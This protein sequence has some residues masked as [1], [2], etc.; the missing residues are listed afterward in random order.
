[1]NPETGA[2][3]RSRPVHDRPVKAAAKRAAD[4]ALSA[5]A[6]SSKGWYTTDEEE[7]KKRV[8]RGETEPMK[9]ENL[10]PGEALFGTFAVVS[11][12]SGVPYTVEIRSLGT[13]DNSCS[14]PDFQVNGLGTCKHIEAVLNRLRKRHPA[15]FRRG[16]AGGSSRV[17]I[18][19]NRRGRIE[20]A[21]SLPPR[22]MPAL[23]KFV[24]RFF[25]T[26]G[27]MRQRAEDAVP[28]I[29]RAIDELPDHLRPG[30]RLAREVTEWAAAKARAS[31]R[32]AARDAFLA[33]VKAGRR[34][35]HVLNHSL[36]PYQQEGMLHLAF[37][38]RVMLVD[39]MG[40]GKTVQAIAACALLRE[41]RGVERVLVVTP[42]SLKTEWE[43]QIKKFTGL[44]YRII[45]GLKHGRTPAYREP[46]F[47][48]LVNYEQ[49]LRDVAEINSLLSPDIVI[50]DEAQRIKNWHSKTAQAVKRL[51]SPFSFVLTGTPLENR[52]DEI[53]SI[54]EFL[55]PSVFGPL[56]RF[57]REF[58]E[59]DH[60]GKPVGYRNL[61]ELRRRIRPL[62]MRRRKDEVEEQ[63]PE[64]IDNNYFVEMSPEQRS[65]YREY[66]ERVARLAAIA[67][68]RPLTK[69]E[70]DQLQKWLA[71]MRMLCDTPYILDPEMRVCPKLT[72]LAQVIQDLGL[73][74]GRKALV[75]S[76]W[77]RMLDLVRD[78]AAQMK[79][80]FA[81]HTGS[82]PQMRRREEINRFKNDPACNLFLSTDSGGVGL[83]LQA[84]SVV[85]NLDLPWNPAR[86]EQRIARAWRKH[87]QQAVNVVNLVTEDSIEHKMLGTLAVKREL[88]DGVIDG[89]GDLSSLRMPSGRAAFLAKLNHIL[90]VGLPAPLVTERAKRVVSPVLGEASPADRFRQAVV[91][92][93]SN[94]VQLITTRP[95]TGGDRGSATLVVVDADADRLRPVIARMHEA[96]D[97]EGTIEVL[98]RQTY[99]TVQR[100]VGLGIVAW[101]MEA[102]TELHRSPALTRS[103]PSPE[104]IRLKKADELLDQARRKGKMAEVLSHGG[105]DGEALLAAKD[106]VEIAMRAL[107]LIAQENRQDTPSGDVDAALIHAELVSKGLLAEHQAAQ[108][109][110]LRELTGSGT[111]AGGTAQRMLPPS[112]DII[113][114]AG[115][116]VAR[117]ALGR[118]HPVTTPP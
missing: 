109:S 101:P 15:G 39:D 116:A 13:R 35:L 1:M 32:I 54:V 29:S 98:D 30:I 108:V 113:Q 19:L 81:W 36:Y 61:D 102:G 114:T 5:R 75:F 42:A 14:C 2:A 55:D 74:N 11:G 7:I 86:L 45:T 70:A 51:S 12:F 48:N 78:L 4:R 3:V 24:R 25:D 6:T 49:V 100:L 56:F 90:G 28:A 92:E 110:V 79:I 117:R 112:L 77:E 88:A 9:I 118:H 33:D 95:A 43:E 57:N 23:V 18:F 69:E 104:E 60:R 40:L 97:R 96:S 85:I 41:L 106:G 10:D 73:N 22:P 21:M 27:R 83:N 94:R 89:R 105:F 20:I 72:E 63:L 64:R 80:G 62:M 34:S 65:R 50:L 67:K 84:A 91:S 53:Y 68:R 8:A 26:D 115:E 93:L 47:F 99:E 111:L 17:E 31:G 46:A 58:Y 76:E 16:M 38:E 87:Q 59:L 82:V 71:C 37:G 44:S 66:E 107:A 52:I 103:G